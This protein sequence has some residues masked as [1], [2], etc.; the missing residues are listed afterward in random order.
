[1]LLGF[2]E[3]RSAAAAAFADRAEAIPCAETGGGRV[4]ASSS[5]TR[6]QLLI[7]LGLSALAVAACFVAFSSSGRSAS[8]RASYARCYLSTSARTY[9]PAPTKDS[10]LTDVTVLVS[11]CQDLWMKGRLNDP[12]NPR[13]PGWSGLFPAPALTSCRLADEGIAVYPGPAGTCAALGMHPAR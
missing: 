8:P 11:A 7:V 6:S 2:G 4:Q 13:V 10:E 1:L 12:L 3:F 5:R 9:L